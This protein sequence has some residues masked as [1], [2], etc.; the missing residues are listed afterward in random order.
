MELADI[1]QRLGEDFGFV[2]GGDVGDGLGHGVVVPAVTGQM[3]VKRIKG[4]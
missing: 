4:R 2:A 1:G 3:K